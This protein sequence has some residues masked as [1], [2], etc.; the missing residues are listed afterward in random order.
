MGLFSKGLQFPKTLSLVV[1][2]RA[3]NSQN[4]RALRRGMNLQNDPADRFAKRGRPAREGAPLLAG[5]ADYPFTGQV[6]SRGV[7]SIS[8]PRG[9]GRWHGAA[10]TEGRSSIAEAV[11]D[12]RWATS[13]LKKAGAK[14]FYIYH[15]FNLY[16]PK[17][18][19]C[20]SLI[21]NLL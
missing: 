21:V 5:L 14:T 9:E 4:R 3:R 7:L 13:L 17:K 18:P 1:L 8:L 16:P 15:Q 12:A 2:R 10:V 6:K 11:P 19:P 20:G